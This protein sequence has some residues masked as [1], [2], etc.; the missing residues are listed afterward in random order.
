[1]TALFV[2]DLVLSRLRRI[3]ILPVFGAAVAKFLGCVILLA[4]AGCIVVGITIAQFD[5]ELPDY[6]QLAH[7]QPAIMTRVHAGDGRLLAENSSERR[8][9][10]PIESIPKQVVNAFLSAEDKNFPGHPQIAKARRDWVLDRMFENVM[11]AQGEVTQAEAPPLEPKHRQEAEEVKAPYFAEEVRRELLARYGEKLLYRSGLSV[12]TSLDAR[13][14]AAAD[15]ALRAG[16][17]RYERGH[18]GWRGP[19]DRIDPKGNWEARLAKVPIPAVAAAQSSSGSRCPTCSTRVTPSCCSPW[20]ARSDASPV[21]Q[22]STFRA[23]AASAM[24]GRGWPQ[25]P[26]FDRSTAADRSAAG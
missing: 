12:R 16:L 19:L 2:E 4:I 5:R 25:S 7:Y 26:R 24:S 17:V 13:L 14:H 18:G 11:A 15:G 23:V 22:T 10:V 3:R 9:F 20:R 8:V 6:Q 1:M 21:S